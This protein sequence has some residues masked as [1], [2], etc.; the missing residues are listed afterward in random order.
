[1]KKKIKQQNRYI[2]LYQVHI[3]SPKYSGENED[4]TVHAPNIKCAIDRA[5][6]LTWVTGGNQLKAV[7]SVELLGV[8]EN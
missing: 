7:R 6:K 1:M 5:I 4:V 8:S 2:K 3:Q